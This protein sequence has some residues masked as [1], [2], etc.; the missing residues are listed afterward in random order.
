MRARYWSAPCGYD[1]MTDVSRD[2]AGRAILVAE[3]EYTV[4]R[5]LVRELERHGATVVGPVSSLTEA[6][7]LVS[8]MELQGAILDIGL[9]DELAFPVADQL[10]DLGVPF[11]FATAY[12]RDV[13]PRQHRQRV[14]YGKPYVAAEVVASL[15]GAPPVHGDLKSS[16][17]FFS[18]SA[19]WT[20]RVR[21]AE[22]RVR[23]A[24]QAGQA[25]KTLVALVGRMIEQPGNLAL[26]VHRDLL[27]NRVLARI[28]E[29]TFRGLEADLE[30]VLLRRGVELPTADAVF[31]LE[32]GVVSAFVRTRGGID[33]APVGCEGI[34]GLDSLAGDGSRGFRYVVREAGDAL[35]LSTAALS[36]AV[37]ARS[38]LAESI[39]CYAI[40]RMADIADTAQAHVRLS[41]QQRLGRY[42]LAHRKRADAEA[43]NLTHDVLATILGVRRASV[44]DAIHRLEGSGA[45]RNM[46]GRIVINDAD[47]LDRLCAGPS[48]SRLRR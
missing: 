14:F 25:T 36:R 44:T 10:A 3:D 22:G 17:S 33:A 35:R 9:D 34:A 28:S 40:E 39:A 8:S 5:G 26:T 20:L 30:P 4:A 6:A 23:E 37:H 16:P 48:R 11:V 1:E 27:R 15:R 29:Q 19:L 38:D 46:R 41:V 47:L 24:M 7:R 42:I 12:S 21:A 31:F 43:I 45:I 32:S 13:V 18:E 2:L